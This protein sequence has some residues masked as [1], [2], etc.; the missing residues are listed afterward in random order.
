MNTRSS[1]FLCGISL[2]ALCLLLPLV[3]CSPHS[4]GTTQDRA[5]ALGVQESQAIEHAPIWPMEPAYRI[6]QV[7]TPPSLDLG[8]AFASGVWE[9]AELMTPF[10]R[11]GV[12]EP[13]KRR[14]TL[15]YHNTYPGGGRYGYLAGRLDRVAPCRGIGPIIS[16]S[17]PADKRR[18]CPG[19]R[20]DH[21][22]AP[23]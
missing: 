8:E 23:Y 22:G 15:R 20:S 7:D 17:S 19:C 21:I 9:S 10:Y 6:L 12:P 16:L 1:R 14:T 18:R 2:L 11:Q 3:S 4:P 13:P 5:P